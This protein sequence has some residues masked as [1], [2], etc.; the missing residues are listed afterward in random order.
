MN[1]NVYKAA[2]RLH[3]GQLLPQVRKQ[4]S[5]SQPKKFSKRKFVQRQK[6]QKQRDVTM[7]AAVAVAHHAAQNQMKGKVGIALRVGGRIGVRA[8][9]VAAA[10]MTAYDVYQFL[11]D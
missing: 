7:A 5:K 1:E 11:S 10:L 2:W 4:V 6:Q 3:S 9:P 8:I